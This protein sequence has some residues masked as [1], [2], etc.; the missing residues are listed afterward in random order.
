MRSLFF[1]L[2][3][4]VGGEPDSA[5]VP[6]KEP[7][8]FGRMLLMFLIYVQSHVGQN[9]SFFYYFAWIS[10]SFSDR[11]ARAFPPGTAFWYSLF[12]ALEAPGW[13][14]RLSVQLQLR[15]WS[16]SS[17]VWVPHQALCWQLRAWSAS[18]SVSPSLSA[19]PLLTTV[20]VSLKINKL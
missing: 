19:P 13:L 1:V 16:P 15:S 4:E 10:G 3:R 20:S 7:V 17:W 6:C 11:S 5:Y 14:S 2:C 8:L 12:T 9:R 18:D